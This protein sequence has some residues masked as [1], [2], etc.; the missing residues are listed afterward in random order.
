MTEQEFQKLC[1]LVKDEIY[2]KAPK[3]TGNLAHNALRIEYVTPN[4]CRI[5]IDQNI[6]P[7]MP[8]TNEKWISPKWNGKKN[9]N[10]GWWQGAVI[11]A[12]S[13]IIDNADVK[14]VKV[15]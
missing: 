12:V 11:E 4:K 9:P 14:D 13:A 3:D 8:Y 7:Y 10:E 15:K 1:E 5:Y 6:A 2:K